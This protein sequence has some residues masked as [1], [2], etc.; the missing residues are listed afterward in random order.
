MRTRLLDRQ[1]RL[2]EYLTSSGAI[3]GGNADESLN[4]ALQGI[5][6]GLLR[7][8][9]CFSHEKRM[10]KISAVFPRTFQLLGADHAAILRE[11][12]EACP[13]V[14][15]TRLENARQFYNFLCTRW[16]HSPPEPPYLGEVAACEFAF[17]KARVGG[18]ARTSEPAGSEQAPRDGIRRPPGVILLRCAYDVRPIFEGG[19][20]D[21]APVRR[22]T[23]L[24]IAVPPHA[25]HP[26]VFELLPPAFDMLA[27]LDDWTDRF[28]LGRSPELDELI[29]ALTEHGLVEVRR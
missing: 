10:E 15:I 25:E 27:A 28:A 2:L 26:K 12:V 18:E 5:D 11:F 20:G 17:V 4:P 23:P 3:F 14:D 29:C 13:P 21:A 19:P 16:R 22:D 6:R 1:G 24:A 8:E 7:L 9:A